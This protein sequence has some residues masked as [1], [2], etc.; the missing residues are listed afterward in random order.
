[1][2]NDYP[3]R[4]KARTHIRNL[5]EG[6]VA[7]TNRQNVQSNALQQQMRL[8]D[9]QIF[10]TQLANLIVFEIAHPDLPIKLIKLVKHLR[11]E[12]KITPSCKPS[13]IDKAYQKRSNMARLNRRCWAE[14]KYEVLLMDIEPPSWQAVKL[15]I[16]YT[17]IFLNYCDYKFTGHDKS[18]FQ[19]AV[20]KI[21]INKFCMRFRKYFK[22]NGGIG[23]F[24]NLPL[25]EPTVPHIG[26]NLIIGMIV[27]LLSYT[28]SR[29]N[30]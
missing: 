6:V 17:I 5:I 8:T 29:M 13:E 20:R 30:S 19:N 14:C 4:A 1:M 3:E 15:T 16:K 27:I 24:L 9:D 25:G 28:V 21:I 7:N 18:D 12:V 2:S 10:E 11:Q 23:F 22:S 26:S